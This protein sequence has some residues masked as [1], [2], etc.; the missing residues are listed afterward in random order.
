MDFGKLTRAHIWIIGL[1]IAII[2]ATGFYFLGIAK[3]KEN[4]NLVQQ[5]IKTADDTIARR[6][7]NERDLEKAKKEVADA[8]HTFAVTTATKMPKP[9]IDLRN[10][11]PDAQV[12]AMMEL[13][14]E[15]KR[16][17]DM[18]QNFALSTD[19]VAVRTQFGVPAPPAD[20]R[21]IPTTV[22]EIPL[23]TVTA[24]GKFEDVLNYMRRWNK[25]GRLVSVD[26]LQLQGTSPLLTGTAQLTVY[27][28]PET[29]PEQQQAPG[30]RK[31]VV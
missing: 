30:D 3:T 12:K 21:L 7:Q 2:V 20:P 19:N 26:G 15:P 17:Y 1:V 6:V 22:I 18:A 8:R 31:S 13:W 5:R 10:Q 29:N 11:D 4:L 25:F 23:G 27:I 16:L 14:K 9:P 24:Y 28:F